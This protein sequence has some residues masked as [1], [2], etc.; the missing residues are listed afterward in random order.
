VAQVIDAV[1]N[2]SEGNGLSVIEAVAEAVQPCA[3]PMAV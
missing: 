2:E 3:D 1:K